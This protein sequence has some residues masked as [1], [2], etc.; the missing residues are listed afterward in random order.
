MIYHNETTKLKHCFYTIIWAL[1]LMVLYR[2]SLFVCLT[3]FTYNE[4][5]S[6]LWILVVICCIAG[7]AITVKN[8]R[9]SLSRLTVVA[10][11]YGLYSLCSFGNNYYT[12]KTLLFTI[13]IIVLG[14]QAISI[15][16][17]SKSS[18]ITHL[19]HS[20]HFIT[21]CYLAVFIACIAIWN[22]LGYGVCF[23]SIE[24]KSDSNDNYQLITSELDKWISFT[25]IEKIDKLQTIANFETD[26]LRLPHELNVQASVM[27]YYTCGYYNPSTRTI[28]INIDYL[29]T[30]SAEDLYETICHES[31][32]AFQ[33]SLV[34]TYCNTPEKLSKHQKE[35]AKVYKF[36]LTHYNSGD[37][38][39]DPY[40]NQSTESDS[41]HYAILELKYLRE[42]LINEKGG[43]IKA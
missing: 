17:Y 37:I 25:D 31:Y 26:R 38:D 20:I 30:A 11:P 1:W 21:G 19:F 24:P 35:K 18:K 27:H 28:S 2:K 42:F 5:K 40:Y 22:M 41:R 9:N 43:K 36:E 34:N 23:S 6:I 14:V 32:H 15:I 29:N 16:K 33:Y 13:A 4:S 10:I 3:D 7:I 8:R 39:Y 12:L